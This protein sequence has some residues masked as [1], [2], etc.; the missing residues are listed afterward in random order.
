MAL[1]YTVTRYD[2]AL[3][4]LG[5]GFAIAQL[6]LRLC[7]AGLIVF[8][9]G[10]PAGG[11]MSDWIAAT[12]SQNPGLVGYVFLIGPVCCVIVGIA[13]VSAASDRAC[14]DAAGGVLLGSALGLVVSFHDPSAAATSFAAGAV[15]SGLWLTGPPL[16]L[17]RQ[18]Q[19]PW[20]PIAGRIFGAG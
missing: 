2:Q 9:I 11:L 14:G 1:L 8:A 10:V 17:W 18:F 20:F 5:I 12:L 13:L 3:P 15:L 16:L 7:I 6:P 4:L 19:R